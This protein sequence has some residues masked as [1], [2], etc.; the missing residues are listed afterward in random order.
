MTIGCTVLGAGESAFP[1]HQR[2]RIEAPEVPLCELDRRQLRRCGY[3][4][5]LERAGTAERGKILRRAPFLCTRTSIHDAR[6]ILDDRK[7]SC[8][9]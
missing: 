2:L 3:Q 6:V 1:A 4:A 7:S 8:N 9:S 5:H